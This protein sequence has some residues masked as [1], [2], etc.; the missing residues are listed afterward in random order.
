MIDLNAKISVGEGL[1]QIMRELGRSTIPEA[2]SPEITA[3]I[4]FLA[5]TEQHIRNLEKVLIDAARLLS[6]EGQGTKQ[7]VL[8]EVKKHLD[9]HSP[10]WWY[11]K[12]FGSEA[13]ILRAEGFSLIIER[14]NPNSP[15]KLTRYERLLFETY[16]EVG[17]FFKVYK[18][19]L[20][21]AE[22]SDEFAK[23]LN[24]GR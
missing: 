18:R 6:I 20:D 16:A 13:W 8:E 11:K 17:A 7:R 22:T 14:Y 15:T 24:P 5:K 12:Q 3:I 9:D 4:A 10:F 19:Y 2:K 23:T 1:I 21:R